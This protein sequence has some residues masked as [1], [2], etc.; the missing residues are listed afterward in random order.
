[1]PTIRQLAAL[2]GVSHS[3]V[4]RALRDDPQIGEATR[5]R[6]QALAREYHYQ[7]NRLAQGALSGAS[8]LLGFISGDLSLPF[9]ARLLRGIYDAAY[10]AGYQV[11]VTE[12]W[13][14]M[15]RLLQ[16]VHTLLAQRVQG[17]LIVHINPIPL[18]RQA[19]LEIISHNV[20]AVLL[21]HSRAERPLT[22]VCT[23]ESALADLA[24]GY[25]H[26]LGHRHIAF[27]GPSIGAF[28]GERTAAIRQ[29]LTRRGLSSQYLVDWQTEAYHGFSAA[30]TLARALAHRPCP[31]A[32]IGFEDRIAA[33]LI[34]AAQARR[35]SV[36][37]AVSIMGCAN[38]NI[39][40]FTAPPLTSIEQ[41][42]EEIGRRA[43]RHVIARLT[44]PDPAGGD[45]PA[46]IQVPPTL[47]IRDSCAAPA[48]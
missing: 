3:T 9:G 48:R 32:I 30:T 17:M 35:L 10:G 4:S 16:A 46:L 29:A 31:T 27:V 22:R 37:R 19:V 24:V 18:P 6:I 43:C 7:P 42:P 28:R 8:R 20:A 5:R 39:A 21:D 1:M 44:A 34:Q 14:E 13:R 45:V 25:L 11:L 40:E 15:P 41:H 26:D 23:D 2:A 38:L 36:P 12:T 33:A 47:V